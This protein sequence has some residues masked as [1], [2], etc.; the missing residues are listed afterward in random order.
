MTIS[1]ATSFLLE[2]TFLGNQG[3]I[4]FFDMGKPIK[5]LD[6]A[7]QLIASSNAPDSVDIIF[8]GLRPGEKIHEEEILRNTNSSATSHPKIFKANTN[9]Y[10]LNSFER[11]FTMLEKYFHEQNEIEMVKTMKLLV[12]E[13]KSKVSRFEALDS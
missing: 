4:L 6:L 3:E 5:I 2:S 13:F 8:T 10:L 1:E 12:P 11:N 9:S 7:K